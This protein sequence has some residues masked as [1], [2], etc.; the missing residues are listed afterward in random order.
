MKR[1]QQLA[2][3]AGEAVAIPL[4]V[5]FGA[6]ELDHVPAIVMA[7]VCFASLVSATVVWLSEKR[8]RIAIVA[9]YAVAAVSVCAAVFVTACIDSPKIE[10][11]AVF[12]GSS[13]LTVVFATAVASRGGRLER[14]FAFTVY[15]L[16]AAFLVGFFYF[17]APH[18]LT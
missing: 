10:D 15:S 1:E 7:S 13:S 8:E 4:V 5:F 6:V 2:M 14:R 16:E 11:V 17:L 3:A 9:A 18:C 12:T